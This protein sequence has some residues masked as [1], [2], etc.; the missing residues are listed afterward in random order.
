M[1][2]ELL[3]LRKSGLHSLPR[4]LVL[5]SLSFIAPTLFSKHVHKFMAQ[6]PSSPS[7]SFHLWQ[8]LRSVA[9]VWRHNLAADQLFV[10]ISRVDDLLCLDYSQSLETITLAELSAPATADGEGSATDVVVG[11]ASG[12]IAVDFVGASS[13]CA[14][15]VGV[16]HVVVGAGAASA[17]ALEV[18]DGPCA[19]GCHHGDIGCRGGDGERGAGSGQESEDCGDL[20][21]DVV[22]G[23]LLMW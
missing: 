3:V 2:N 17:C 18:F 4:Y 15:V 7:Q 6:T 11:S 12:W 5:S 1:I 22:E 21:F 20:H 10:G 13:L 8:V 19:V 14:A 16:D 9:L 23:G